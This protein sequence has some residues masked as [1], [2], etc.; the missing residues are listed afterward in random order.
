MKK[1]IF[2]LLLIFIAIAVDAQTVNLQW[3]IPVGGSSADAGN[4]I[5]VD[6]AGNV[7]TTGTF[8]GTVVSPV[9]TFISAGDADIFL[10][11]FDPAGAFLWAIQ[12]GGAGADIS[13]SVAVDGSNNVYI[14]GSFTGTVDFD[15]GA[16]GPFTAPGL[17]GDDIDIFVAKFDGL[18]GN[19]IWA[20][21]MGGDYPDEAFSITVDASGGV[22]TTG[23]FRGTANFDPNGSNT[24]STSASAD[25]D[26]FVS[27]LDASGSYVWAS[28]MGGIATDFGTSISLDPDGNVV[29]TGLFGGAADFDPS[30]ST[31]NFTA[32]ANDTYVSK[33][34]GTSGG[35]V[36]AQQIGGP[37]NEQ[38]NAVTVDAM[39]NIY[40]TG[41]FDGT[42]DFNPDPT[43]GTGDFFLTTN[44]GRDIFIARLSS[45]GSFVWAKNIGNSGSGIADRDIGFSIA[46]D[47]SSNVYTTGSF[48]NTADFNPDPTATFNL[49]SVGDRDIFLSVLDSD[50]DFVLARSFGAT[51][52]DQ[53]LSIALHNATGSIHIIGWFAGSADF[54]PGTGTLTLTSNSGSQDVFIMKLS[55]LISTPLRLTDFTAKLA[56][57]S[58]QLQWSTS[59]ELNTSHFEIEKSA[60]GTNFKK[61]GSVKAAG[62]SSSDRNYSYNDQ[63]PSNGTNYYRLKMIDADGSFT[64]SKIV[65]VRM[66]GSTLLQAFPNPAKNVLYVQAT[67]SDKNTL[68]R[69]TDGAGKVVREQKVILNGTTSFTIDISTLPKGIYYLT[70]KDA[71]K[72]Q[73][74]KIIKQ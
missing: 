14:A 48:A 8:Q 44:G 57:Q 19:L 62:N 18:N 66:N 51:G 7:Y 52:F 71:L 34:S 24:R 41:F 3:A 2:T 20:K 11:R 58:V 53:G 59:A 17:A 5:A 9:G 6:A 36:W 55:Q 42:T 37:G 33:L 73:Q 67:G 56:N 29:S 27:K 72:I 74:Q 68:L 70:L 50:G 10:A 63:Q 30:G 38:A 54:D 13:R 32:T 65:V 15:P 45:T 49:T 69:I 28:Q 43:A 64:Y 39:G 46:V 21:Q 22:Y 25:L 40:L 60:N 23:Y 4:S 26:I 12:I 31:V 16:G 1:P 61:T 47:A 35:F